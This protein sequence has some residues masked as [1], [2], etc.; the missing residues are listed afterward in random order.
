MYP[1]VLYIFFS[2]SPSKLQLKL[3]VTL[4]A[5]FDALVFWNFHLN[6]ITINTYNIYCIFPRMRV[7][8]IHIMSDGFIAVKKGSWVFLHTVIVCNLVLT[9]MKHLSWWSPTTT[10]LL[11]IATTTTFSGGKSHRGKQSGYDGAIAVHLTLTRE[12]DGTAVVT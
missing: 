3:L 8:Q 10:S 9:L 6:H 4:M 1:F 12:L 2:N 7:K 11:N 5:F